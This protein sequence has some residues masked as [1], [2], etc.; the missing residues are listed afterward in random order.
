MTAY[1]SKA[2]AVICIIMEAAKT[3]RKMVGYLGA[4][5]GTLN[6]IGLSKSPSKNTM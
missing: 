4:H 1:S 5:H 6:K 3:Y 2:M